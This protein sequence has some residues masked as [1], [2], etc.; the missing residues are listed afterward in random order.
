MVSDAHRGIR[1]V[2]VLSA[3]ARRPERV[4]PA[5]RFFDV[6]LDLVVDDRINPS[7][8]E[9]GVPARVGVVRRNPDETV[10]AR[11][12]LEPAVGIVALMSSVADLMPASS[13]AVSSI[14]S[15]LNFRR[16]AQRL[17]MRNSM[18]AQSWLS[19]PPAPECTSM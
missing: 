19:V 2:D 11:L 5:V 10:H 16:S 6:D 14:S 8:R 18:R 1:G 13:P 9:A 4:D 17:Y 7:R 12:G 3:R 15:T